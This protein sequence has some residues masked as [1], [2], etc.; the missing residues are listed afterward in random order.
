MSAF[1]NLVVPSLRRLCSFLAIGL[2]WCSQVGDAHAVLVPA[3]GV[4]AGV[5][6]IEHGVFNYAGVNAAAA[7]NG[8]FNPIIADGGAMSTPGFGYPGVVGAPT[9]EVDTG[10]VGLIANVPIFLNTAPN[11]PS[12]FGGATTQ[13]VGVAG[14]GRA[15]VAAT[16]YTLSD[17]HVNGSGLA[18]TNT[19]AA[20]VVYNNVGGAINPRFAQFFAAGVNLTPGGFGMVGVKSVFEVGDYNALTGAFTVDSFWEPLPILLAFDGTGPRA[21]MIQGQFFSFGGVG[22]SLTFGAVSTTPP[23]AVAVGKSVRIRGTISLVADPASIEMID[24][25]LDMLPNLDGI[26]L[27]AGASMNSGSIVPE[28]GSVLLLALGAGMALGFA[29]RGRRT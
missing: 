7:F 21:D 22:N 6:R 17:N 29:H 23:L 15:G 19:F 25:P 13:L 24:L 8:F 20:S 4:A 27:V 1:R 3:T 26:D 10:G 16:N 28:P 5:G 18:S 12:G 14:G 9:F 11:A 2:L